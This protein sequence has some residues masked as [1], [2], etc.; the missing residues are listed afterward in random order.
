MPALV[1]GALTVPNVMSASRSD[2]EAVDRERAIDN[3]MLSTLLGSNKRSWR[4]DVNF[5][6]VAELSALE[7]ALNV[8]PP[9]ACSGDL[10]GGIVNCHIERHGGDIP[11]GY[12]PRRLNYSFTLH[13]T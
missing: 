4:F 1:I 9:I 6:T 10:L 8:A 11:L 12:S 13:E 3:T 5:N 2:T 7:A